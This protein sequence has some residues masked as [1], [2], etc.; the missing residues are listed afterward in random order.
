MAKEKKH[1]QSRSKAEAVYELA[2]SGIPTLS[3]STPSAKMLVQKAVSVL[4]TMDG[5]LSLILTR[6]QV[7]AKSL[8]EYSAVREM[9]GV[10]DVLAFKLIAEI[11][12]IRRLYSAKTLIAWAGIAPPLYES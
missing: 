1:H 4:R 7:F 10:G 6:M 11:N 5:S 2:S 3:S 8:L 12:D 9:S